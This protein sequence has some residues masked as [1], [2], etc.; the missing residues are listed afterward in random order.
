MQ[1]NKIIVK[2]LGQSFIL[3]Q[4]VM[5]CLILTS[6]GF[7]KKH[8]ASRLGISYRTVEKHIINARNKIGIHHSGQLLN[9]LFSSQIL[10]YP[11]AITSSSHH[12][13]A[14]PTTNSSNTT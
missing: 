14:P 9:F 12:T 13:I 7:P 1:T 2:Y 3:T 8:I 11:S 10:R 5:E 4:R 6:M